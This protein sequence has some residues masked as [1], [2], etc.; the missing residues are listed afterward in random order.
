MPKCPNSEC[1]W[2][3]YDFQY[4]LNFSSAKFSNMSS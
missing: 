1:A 2:S 3:S 4:F